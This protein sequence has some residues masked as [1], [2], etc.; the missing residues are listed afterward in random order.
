[1]RTY[2]NA[3]LILL[4]AIMVPARLISQKTDVIITDSE[5]NFI[6]QSIIKSLSDYYVSAEVASVMVKTIQERNRKGQYSKIK[7]GSELSDTLTKHLRDLS[8]DEHLGLIFS[9]DS[10]PVEKVTPPTPEE[11]ERFKRF[12]S[13]QNYGFE[14]LND[15]RGTSGL[16]N[17]M[18]LS[19]R[20]GE[21]N[22][23]RSNEFFI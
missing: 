15:Y 9:V 11:S 21:R 17:L 18:D 12:A 2:K 1:M 7:S 4:V 8:K 16:W 13:A 19:G 23:Y 10:I 14:K 3:L 20:N 6:V 22:C 5:R